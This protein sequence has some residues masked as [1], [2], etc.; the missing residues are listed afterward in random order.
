MAEPDYIVVVQCHIVKERCSGF[1]CEQAFHRR[2][3]AFAD[4]PADRPYRFLTM[5]CGGCCGKATL[6]KLTNLLRCL[7]KHEGA[8]RE[9]VVVHLSSCMTKD[10]FHSPRCMFTDYIKTLV[11]RA[12]LECREGTHISPKAE[13]RRRRGVYG[14]RGGASGGC[15]C[16]GTAATE[17]DE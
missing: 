7:K 8:G 5:T 16:A 1:F 2:T 9:R 6:R 14:P 13:D 17:A 3:G 11:A 12:G 4:Y 15:D 10:N